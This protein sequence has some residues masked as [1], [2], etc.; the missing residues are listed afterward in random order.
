[1]RWHPLGRRRWTTRRVS[2]ERYTRHT[3]AAATDM[4]ELTHVWRSIR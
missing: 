3:R 1:V 4:P 2:D